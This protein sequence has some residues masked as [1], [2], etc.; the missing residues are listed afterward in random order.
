M[1]MVELFPS[2][3]LIVKNL[4]IDRIKKLEEDYH[5]VEIVYY[6]SYEDGLIEEM[7]AI[8]QEIETT[9]TMLYEVTRSLMK[10]EP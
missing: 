5:M 8:K 10:N 6:N 7:K 9:R 2:E 3:M 4:L 1:T